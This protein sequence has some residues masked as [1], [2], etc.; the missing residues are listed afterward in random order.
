[1]TDIITEA[2]AEALERENA[3]LRNNVAMAK[4]QLTTVR[5]ALADERNKTGRLERQLEGYDEELHDPS[6]QKGIGAI[7]IGDSPLFYE[8]EK[9][10][11]ALGMGP[12]T[13]QQLRALGLKG[14]A[15]QIDALTTGESTP[16]E[17]LGEVIDHGPYEAAEAY[18]LRLERADEEDAEDVCICIQ[19]LRCDSCGDVVVGYQSNARL[20]AGEPS[21][22]CASPLAR[23]QRLVLGQPRTPRK[24]GEG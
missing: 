14:P 4:R 18:G 8:V 3:E 10:E 9:I 22:C 1:M 6:A 16:E 24:L 23:C 7:P 11:A 12:T 5:K 13:D 21:P 19:V 15:D 2:A 20:A 17:I